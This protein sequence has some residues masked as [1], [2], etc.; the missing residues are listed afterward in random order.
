M[1]LA[2][3]GFSL[4]WACSKEVNPPLLSGMLTSVAN[5]GGFLA[6]ALLQPLVGWVMDLGWQGEMVNGARFYDVAAWRNGVLVV[7]LCSLMGATASWWIRGRS[8]PPSGTA[9]RTPLRASHQPNAP[10]G[11]STTVSSHFSTKARSIT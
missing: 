11:A 6:G 4:T 3:A 8:A 2:T 7:T 10:S 5:M 9:A 1:G